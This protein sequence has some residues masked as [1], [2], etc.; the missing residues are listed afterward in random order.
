MLPPAGKGSSGSNGSTKRPSPDADSDSPDRGSM[1]MQYFQ[2]QMVMFKERMHMFQKNNSPDAKKQNKLPVPDQELLKIHVNQ[3]DLPLSLRTTS[4]LEDN[5]PE[6]EPPL[7][8]DAAPEPGGSETIEDEAFN[9][10]RNRAGPNAKPSM[11]PAGA[12]KATKGMKRPAAK[13]M[14]ENMMQYHVPLPDAKW[15]G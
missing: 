5:K 11:S 8:N 14:V 2:Q 7:S 6:A 10:L 15:E 9:I 12:T 13:T 3:A 1:P 4:A